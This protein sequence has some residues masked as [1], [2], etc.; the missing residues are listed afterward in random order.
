MGHDVW[1]TVC[2]WLLRLHNGRLETRGRR[3]RGDQALQV[4]R[5]GLQS[6]GE[7]FAFLEAT[8]RTTV[9]KLS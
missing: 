9:Q 4:G 2:T 7:L 8:A 1:D 5:G 6:R 3:G